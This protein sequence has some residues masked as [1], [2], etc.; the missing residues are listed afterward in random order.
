M[1][2]NIIVNNSDSFQRSI[3]LSYLVDTEHKIWEVH[4]WDPDA[5]FPEKR[6]IE[7]LLVS[8]EKPTEEYIVNLCLEKEITFCCQ[9]YLKMKRY[10]WSIEEFYDERFY[11]IIPEN[12]YHK[13]SCLA[14]LGRGE[15]AI[16]QLSDW[17]DKL[18]EIGVTVELYD[19][20]K[21]GQKTLVPV[22]K[23]KT[24]EKEEKLEIFWPDGLPL[25]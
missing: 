6:S 18:R 14:V 3:D 13:H 9:M 17:V 4:G 11:E 16:K 22:L 15:K 7:F 8:I 2:L 20:N 23:V 19:S 10:N 24:D 21:Y 12:A 25:Y 1:K 5:N